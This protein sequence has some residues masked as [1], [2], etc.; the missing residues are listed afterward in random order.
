MY[1]GGNGSGGGSGCGGNRAREQRGDDG[2]VA[3]STSTGIIIDE[4]WSS[5][6]G[7]YE[8]ARVPSPSPSPPFRASPQQPTSANDSFASFL[9]TLLHLQ[10]YCLENSGGD[11]ASRRQTPRQR[12]DNNNISLPNNCICLLH[13]ILI[14]VQF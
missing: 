4:N 13:Q 10:G 6:E 9:K 3:A 14:K 12:H 8:A 7:G 5:E 2:A 1:F 11:N